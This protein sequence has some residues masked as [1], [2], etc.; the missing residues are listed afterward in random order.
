VPRGKVLGHLDEPAQLGPAVLRDLL[1]RPFDAGQHLGQ[2]ARRVDDVALP[3][4]L[5][6]GHRFSWVSWRSSRTTIRTGPAPVF[7]TRYAT[8]YANRLSGVGDEPQLAGPLGQFGLGPDAELRV[9]PG[10]VAL[11]GALPDEEPPADLL[12]RQPGGG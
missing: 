4:L 5:V 7:R 1:R 10:E 2:H 8:G 6:G 11:D 3:E 9:G 12:R